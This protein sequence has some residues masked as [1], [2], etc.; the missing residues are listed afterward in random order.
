ML[1]AVPG[2]FPGYGTVYPNDVTA[3]GSMVVGYNA[4][5]WSQATGF[6]WTEETGMVDVEDYL[7]DNGITL[8]PWFDIRTLTGVS[9]DGTVMVGI[10]VDGEFPFLHRS[11]IIRSYATGVAGESEEPIAAPL[12]RAFPNPMVG[13]TTLALTMPRAGSVSL[14]MYNVA[15]RLVR[16]VAD[17]P[18]EAGRHEIP[19][20]GRDAEGVDVPSGIYFC[21]VKAG[22]HEVTSKVTVLR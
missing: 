11:F 8:D 1:G 7:V 13:A 19:W 20:D 9:D 5:D 2:T 15:G 17:G 3:D 21:R 18:L 4:F 10:G 22:Q 14:E 6:I 12:V 16:R